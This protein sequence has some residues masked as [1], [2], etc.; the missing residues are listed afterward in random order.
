VRRWR[1]SDASKTEPLMAVSVG[2]W[3]MILSAGCKMSQACCSWASL[4]TY[5]TNCAWVAVTSGT[6]WCGLMGTGC[7]MGLLDVSWTGV[8]VTTSTSESNAAR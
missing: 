1:F 2:R 4:I 6:G 7:M 5:A 3:F 8:F